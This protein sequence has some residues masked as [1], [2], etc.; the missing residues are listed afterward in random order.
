MVATDLHRLGARVCAEG[1]EYRVWAPGQREMSVVVE[2]SPG[3]V[4]LRLELDDA[5]YWRGFD[6]AGRAGDLY[7]FRR[8]DGRLLPDVASRFQ[9]RGVDGPSECIDPSAY[10]WRCGGWMRPGW[11]GQTVYEIHLGTFTP[12]GTYRAAA[13]RLSAVRDLGAEA[14]EL[15]PLAAFGGARNWGYDGVALYAPSEAYGR[16]DDLR[17]LVD[18]AHTCGLAVILD[19]VYNH[20]GPAGCYLGEYSPDY[21][22]SDRKT[23]WGQPFNLDGPGSR[24]VRDFLVG[25]A[26]AWLDDYRFDGLR[27]DATHAIAD[28]SPH[29]LLAEIAEA[30]QARGGFVIAED[31][32]N[33]AALLRGRAAGGAGF[34]ALWA[35]DFHHEVRVAVTGIRD[36]YF[37]AFSGR[38]AALASL[39]NRGWTYCGQAYEP[40][41]GRRRGSAP[42]ELSPQ[43][44]VVCI[45][46]HDQIGNRA[47]GERLE[48]LIPPAQYRAAALLLCLSP[49]PP[50]LFM[51]QEWAASTPFRFFTAHG[52][53]LGAAVAA[54]RRREFAGHGSFGSADAV[55]DPEA[56]A[57]FASS[58]LD[59]NE[60]RAPAHRAVLNLYTAALRERRFALRA[61]GLRRGG[62]RATDH[63]ELVA[64]RYSSPERE[65][66]LLTVLAAGAPPAAALPPELAPPAGR[67]WRPILHSEEDRFGGSLATIETGTAVEPWHWNRPGPW[68]LWLE[69]VDEGTRD[70]TH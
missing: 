26:A 70:G 64:V 18:A 20:V 42:D 49:Y 56:E 41:S 17:A 16:P 7:R 34:D 30:V 9:P 6:P 36:A 44:F 28:D 69:A 27:L 61:A 68:S 66:L 24:P 54:G 50:L 22:H 1:V 3:P 32:R 21:F 59:W 29:H 45:E 23:P 5:G 19:V 58:K 14:I 35:D 8:R 53:E 63:G 38:A 57:T 48:H 67:S 51:G 11:A 55:A 31:E 33:E 40:W 39:L 25:N 12:E 2:R 46:N 65:F 15:M 4:A 47:A 13:E 60:R 62:W 10:P 37:R 52:G 43:A